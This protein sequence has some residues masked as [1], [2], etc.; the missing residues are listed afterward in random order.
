MQLQDHPVEREDDAL[1][2]PEAARFLGCS[3]SRLN[4]LRVH[5][6]G[7]VFTKD[8]A[9]VRYVR[10]DLRAYRD[11]RKQRSTSG[12]RRGLKRRGCPE[13]SATAALLPPQVAGA[14]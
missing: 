3:A 6:G 7:P 13:S 11:A 5:G 1:A 4:K 2:T 10:A 9:T 12:I 8:G 14:S